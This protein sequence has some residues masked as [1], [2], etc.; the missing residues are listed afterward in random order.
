ML[1][2][3]ISSLT[4]SVI[5]EMPKKSG[6]DYISMLGSIPIIVILKLFILIFTI[7]A[8][9]RYTGIIFVKEYTY[10]AHHLEENHH[11]FVLT[12]YICIL[13]AN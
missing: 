13:Y 4:G 5:R 3:G 6:A 8:L 1:E 10:L 7:S 2:S 11:V 12:H 9:I